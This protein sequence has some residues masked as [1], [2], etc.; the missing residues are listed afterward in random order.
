MHCDCQQIKRIMNI[1]DKESDLKNLKAEE[2][3]IRE[4]TW[5]CEA[6]EKKLQTSILNLLIINL[7]HL[8]KRET[9][10]I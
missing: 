6:S 8:T 4:K 9:L 10:I 5:F 1:K 2:H 7:L 3:I